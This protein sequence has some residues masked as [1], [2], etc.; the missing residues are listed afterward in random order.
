[1]GVSTVREIV[2][3]TCQ[4]I[5]E[6]LCS[7]YLAPPNQEEWK[8]ISNDFQCMTGLPHCVGAIDG[9]HIRIKC[10]PNAG[11]LYFNY[12]KYH[13]IVLLAAC[14]SNYCFT[15]VDIGAFGG[16]SD[17]GVLSASSFGKKILDKTI[18]LP[19][20]EYLTNSN[21]K[22]PYFFVGD[23]AFPLRTNIMRPYPGRLL[24]EDKDIF[25]KTLS[26]ARVKIENTFGIMTMRW[27]ILINI[28]NCFPK[29]AEIFV[30]A[31]VLL[32]NFVKMNDG[33]YC[34]PEY[35][36]SF[37]GDKRIDGLWRKEVQDLEKCKLFT[38]FNAPRNAFAIR[39]TLKDF[40][41]NNRK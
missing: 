37:D 31:I 15:A 28:I 6:E 23:A 9:K 34:P 18:N 16:Q 32:H 8:R 12:K 33:Q 7:I 20:D 29:N 30:K 36:D 27:R 40:I 21:V 14:D 39:E 11:S 41:I 3:E 4:I 26:K 19:P 38:R 5:W 13:S 22:C 17:G 25:N 1:M 24:S 35:I 10:P 2:L